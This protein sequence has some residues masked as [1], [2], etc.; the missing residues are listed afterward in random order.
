MSVSSFLLF[1]Y[2]YLTN[3]Y[4]VC[5]T[6]A[7]MYFHIP[8]RWEGQCWYVSSKGQPYHCSQHSTRWR[9]QDHSSYRWGTY[10]RTLS[11]FQANRL[12]E[13]QLN[14]ARYDRTVLYSQ[15]TEQSTELLKQ[16]FEEWEIDRKQIRLFGRLGAGRFGEV[17]KGLWNTTTSVAV[18]TLM[19]GTRSANDFLQEAKFRMSLHHPK[20][21][22]LHAV[23]TK[24]EPI[25][26][27][28]GADETRQCAGLPAKWRL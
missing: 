3:S 15:E 26:Y 20:M 17:W 19:P 4:V 28:D 9:G 24:D 27:C 14:T 25:Y 23:C 11:I 10:L 21:V 16:D 6:V 1:F 13:E 2:D 12:I 18:K 5:S 7:H 22:K 8:G